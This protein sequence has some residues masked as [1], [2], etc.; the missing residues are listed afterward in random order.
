MIKTKLEDDKSG[1]NG[2]P[3]IYHE[4]HEENEEKNKIVTDS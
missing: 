3:F 1:R 2:N 4:E